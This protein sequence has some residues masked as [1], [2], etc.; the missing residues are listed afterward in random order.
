MR[1]ERSV[2]NRC[3][4]LQRRL[5]YERDPQAFCARYREEEAVLAERVRQA[6]LLLPQ[7][8][9]T[10]P[11]LELIARLGIELEVDGHRS[12]I[13]LLKAALA[14]AALEGAT[15]L[16]AEHVY[17]AAELVLPH[18]LRRLPFEERYFAAEDIRQ[19]CERLFQE[20]VTK[21]Q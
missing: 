1:G 9:Y 19:L 11:L 6:R 4:V 21:L 15:E 2:S 5:D 13:M 14:T 18:R 7:L 12:D 16:S 17:T 20:C 10:E 3:E 8:R